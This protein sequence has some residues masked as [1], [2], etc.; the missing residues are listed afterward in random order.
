MAKAKRLTI[1]RDGDGGISIA[2]S[3]TECD[4]AI[5]D[6]KDDYNLEVAYLSAAAELLPR[7]K[8]A[9]KSK[10]EGEF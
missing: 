6:G 2:D 8:A 4:L 1:Y 7:I 10:K 3:V 5:I 9:W